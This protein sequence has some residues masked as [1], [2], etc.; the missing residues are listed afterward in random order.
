MTAA[1][2][3]STGR[4]RRRNAPSTRAGLIS[5]ATPRISAMFA[6]VEPMTFPRAISPRPAIA[7]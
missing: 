3:T 2:A 5:G 6:M 1:L 4:P 7:A